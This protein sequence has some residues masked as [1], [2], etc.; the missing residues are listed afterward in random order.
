MI[1]WAQ[2]PEFLEL[3]TGW[4]IK[5]LPEVAEFIA[6]QSP[7]SEHYNEKGE[8]RPF[9]QGSAE[10]GHRF[11]SYSIFSRVGVKIAPAGSTIISVRAPVGEVNEADRDYVIGRGVGALVASDLDAHF[12]FH[13]MQRWKMCLARVGQGTTFD[14]VTARQF[15]QLQVPLPP[16][17]EQAAIA[18]ILDAADT[19][20][21]RARVAVEKAWV[22][23]RNLRETLVVDADW[24]L[25]RL[26]GFIADGPTNGVYRPE[27][28]YGVEG[29]PIIRI[30]SFGVG[31]IRNI[32]G[33]RRVRLPSVLRDRYTTGEGDILINRVNSL[34]FIGKAALVPPMPETTIF[35]SNMMR[36]R[37]RDT[38]RA[39]YLIEV[40]LSSVAKRHWLM[41]AKAAVNQASINQ[42]DVASL[43]IPVP[44]PEKQREIAAIMAQQR[45]VFEAVSAR[46]AALERLKRGLMQDLLTG[47]VRVKTGASAL[48]VSV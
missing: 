28:D 36:M 10:F 22:L 41:R 21:E 34:D 29:T 31:T 4:K 3:P 37:L 32:A 27:S 47:R 26:G 45:R 42:R 12:L 18:H 8:G 35:E 6:G 24:P 39:D 40:L 44:S 25:E 30:D 33:L 14:A 13:G 11:P 16:P 23:G 46:L 20:I 17:D 43:R 2:L 7:D 1:R 9:L 19:A 48:T 15:D 5:P 38:L